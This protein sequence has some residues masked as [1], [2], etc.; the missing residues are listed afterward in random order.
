MAHP[1]PSLESLKLYADGF[2]KSLTLRHF[3]A[4]VDFPAS[5][6]VRVTLPI[7]PEHRGGLGSEAVNGGILAAMFDLVIGC[8][9]AL[10]DP[11][12]RSATMQLSMNFERALLGDV[13]IAEGWID[14]AGKGTAF[15]S[16]VLK[17][18][19]GQICAR[20]QGVIRIFNS[21]WTNGDSPAIN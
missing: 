9:A 10:I 15:S 13:L 1:T 3:G 6:L 7:R 17:D 21:P 14:R 11:K 19:T 18:S 20:A 4:E 8:S 5:N 12:R 16:G 2:N